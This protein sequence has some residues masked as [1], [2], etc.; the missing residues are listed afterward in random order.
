MKRWGTFAGGAGLCFGLVLG[1]S[2][3]F[4]RMIPD[5]PSPQD[6]AA[7]LTHDTELSL[8]CKLC[9]LAAKFVRAPDASMGKKLGP[10]GRLIYLA[11]NVHNLGVVQFYNFGTSTIA[12]SFFLTERVD[13]KSKGSSQN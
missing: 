3:S 13:I 2:Y 4:P 1:S 7:L 6:P 10:K 9:L 11:V 8:P 12:G 5:S